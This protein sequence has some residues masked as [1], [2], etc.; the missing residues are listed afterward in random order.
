MVRRFAQ[1]FRKR[2]P[3]S[4]DDAPWSAA[5]HR[6]VQHS[7]ARG[8]SNAANISAA[9]CIPPC[10]QATQSHAQGSR[11][12]EPIPSVAAWSKPQRSTPQRCQV[13]GRS[14]AANAPAHGSLQLRAAP[15]CRGLE[16]TRVNADRNI[17]S[18]R[19]PRLSSVAPSPAMGRRKT[20]DVMLQQ[21]N[22][23]QCMALLSAGLRFRETDERVTIESSRRRIAAH[24]GA[25]RANADPAKG[26]LERGA[27]AGAPL[28]VALPRNAPCGYAPGS[29]RDGQCNNV[30]SSYVMQN[31]LL[32]W[33]R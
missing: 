7:C 5:T 23:A 2:E 27:D 17:I 22:V 14:N 25:I 26:L 19:V 3:I 28:R 30:P 11:K 29:S 12:L 9:H 21:A 16:E 8:R 18:R 32:R 31:S 4:K 33:V 10:R 20:V 15:S 13:E 24:G 6:L 1:G